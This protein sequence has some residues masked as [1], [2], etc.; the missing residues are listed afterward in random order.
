MTTIDKEAVLKRMTEEKVTIGVDTHKYFHVAVALSAQGARLGELTVAADAGGYEQL[1][2]WAR[3]L[4]A[5]WCFG[6]EGCGSY[7]QGLV[8]H[9]R[10]HDQRVVEAG[11]PDRRDRRERGKSDPIDAENAAA[12]C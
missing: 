10:R 8:S 4:G 3:S 1:L 9:L 6:V 2:V 12:R 11:R 5:P 7:G